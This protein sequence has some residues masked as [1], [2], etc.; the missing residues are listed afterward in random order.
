MDFRDKAQSLCPSDGGW[1]RQSLIRGQG[2]G[3]GLGEDVV[4]VSLG[5]SEGEV[6]RDIGGGGQAN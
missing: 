3:A 4:E 6:P 2:K 5:Q 1:W